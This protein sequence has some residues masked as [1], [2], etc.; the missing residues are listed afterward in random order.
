MDIGR[1]ISL[2]TFLTDTIGPARSKLRERG[3]LEAKRDYARLLT[4]LVL[5]CFTMTWLLSR[6]Y[7]T[8]RLQEPQ[9]SLWLTLGEGP[10]PPVPVQTVDFDDF[11]VPGTVLLE[12][13]EADLDNDGE[14]EAVLVFGP[15]DDG[16]GPG[17]GGIAIVAREAGEYRKTWEA[18]TSS[19]G[20][21]VDAVIRDINKDGILEVLLFKSTEGGARYSLRIFAWDGTEYTSLRPGGPV[22]LG[23]EAFTSA[24]YPPQVRNVDSTD[25][26]EIVVFDDEPSSERLKVIVYQWDGEAY[27]PVDWI[28]M[29]GPLPPAHGKE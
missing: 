24:Y 16:H 28:V 7:V 11:L 8:A 5:A 6:V 20:Q 4:I 3:S 15:N 23:E 9:L 17:A 14:S 26:E 18:G 12:K 2:D 19:E 13:L 29:L 1:P 10:T 25:L 21:V 22:G 27:A